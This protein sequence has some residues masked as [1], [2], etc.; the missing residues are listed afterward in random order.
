M[1]WL[2][3]KLLGT[4]R[5]ITRAM[6]AELGGHYQNASGERLRKEL[7]WT[8]IDFKQSVRDTLDWIR[9]TFMSRAKSN[10]GS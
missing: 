1:D 6:V 9:R 5:Q 2:Q 8:T 4:R 3:H 10:G 7:G